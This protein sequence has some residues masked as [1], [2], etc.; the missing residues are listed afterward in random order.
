VAYGT[1]ARDDRCEYLVNIDNVFLSFK[2]QKVI[3]VEE[4]AEE[5][6]HEDSHL[7]S[8]K[9]SN[10]ALPAGCE[11]F[12]AWRRKYIPTYINFVAAA[13]DPWTIEDKVAIAAMQEVWNAVF[14]N[15]SDGDDIPHTVELREATAEIV[16]HLT[17]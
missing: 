15:R 3:K 10:A 12:N 5:A 16:S 2:L 1:Q 9:F 8:R 17:P 11:Q 4:G 13:N 7:N 6:S 14:L